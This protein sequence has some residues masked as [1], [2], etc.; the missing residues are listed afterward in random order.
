MNKII[1]EE[2]LGVNLKVLCDDGKV[3]TVSLY[4]L[5][6]NKNSNMTIDDEFGRDPEIKIDLHLECDSYMLGVDNKYD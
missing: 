1:I 3:H 6:N 5:M 2:I 4:G